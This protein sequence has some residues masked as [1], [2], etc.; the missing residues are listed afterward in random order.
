[1]P[2]IAV[3][4]LT[5]FFAW[6]TQFETTQDNVRQDRLAETRRNRTILLAQLVNRYLDERGGIPPASLAALAATPGY[7][8]ATQFINSSGP[9]GDGPFYAVY[10]LNN[11]TNTYNRVIVYNPPA[12]GSINTTDYLL[13]ANNA[14]GGTAPSSTSPWCGNAKGSYWTVDTLSRI[15]TEVAR[16]RT[17]QQL[18]LKKFASLYSAKQYYPNPVGADGQNNGANNNSSATLI[19]LLTGYTYTAATCTGVWNWKG[20]PLAC[21]D[22]YT[23]WGT[24]RTYNY[25]TQDF[26]SLYAEAP[27]QES[28]NPIAIASQLDSRN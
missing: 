14:C 8:S 16:E 7:E 26:I 11:G 1:M 10:A 22:L 21:E 4:L 9:Q 3:F 20:V 18:T 28:G 23:I 24:P 15:S 13:A 2:L 12:D 25:L 5:L 6:Q 17:Q 27:W 19:S